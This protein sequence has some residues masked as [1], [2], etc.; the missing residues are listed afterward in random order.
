[1]LNN[2]NIKPTDVKPKPTLIPQILKI[3]IVP[4]IHEIPIRLPITHTLVEKQNILKIKLLI[5]I[6]NFIKGIYTDCNVINILYL[7]QFS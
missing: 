5:F 2:D 4:P 3:L 7:L 1:M 6:S